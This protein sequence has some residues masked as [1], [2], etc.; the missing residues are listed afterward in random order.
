MA[1]AWFYISGQHQG[2]DERPRLYL[3][4]SDGQP[5]PLKRRQANED[6]GCVDGRVVRKRDSNPDG[7]E[8]RCAVGGAEGYRTSLSL[9]PDSYPPLPQN[10]QPRPTEDRNSHPPASFVSMPWRRRP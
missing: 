2:D 1:R 4:R 5:T 9:P 6:A 7:V 10:R 3:D 8:A